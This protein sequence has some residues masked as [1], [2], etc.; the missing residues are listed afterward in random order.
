MNIFKWIF[1]NFL[2]LATLFLLAF[3]PLYPKIPLFD[4]SNTWVYI[5][6]EDFLV[7]FVL[8][9]WI[10]LLYLK[11]VSFKTP[12][13]LPILIFWLVGAVAT[14]HGVLLIFPTISN[15]FP[16]V[17]FMSLLRHFEYMSLFF[18]AYQGMRERNFLNWVIA[19]LVFTLVAVVVYGLGQRYFGFP[20]YLTMNEEFAKGIPVTLSQ[21][22]RVSSTFA[23][24]YDL[25]AYLVLIIPILV[26]LIFG[27]KNIF[28]KF[29]LL[30]TSVLGF[31]LLFM[32]VSRVS[33]F[34]AIICILLLL[35]FQK[36]KLFLISIPILLISAIFL[37]SFQT[38]LFDR[39]KNTVKEVDVLVDAD[40]GDSIGHL[41]IVEKEQLKNKIVLRKNVKDK[42]ELERALAADKND[43]M[44]S[45]SAVLQHKYI[46]ESVPLVIANNIS[47]GENLPQGT[48]YINLSLSPVTNRL[49]NFF[50]EFSPETK[51]LVGADYLVLEGNFLVKRASAYDMSFTTR[52]QGEWPRAIESFQRNILFG[53]GYGSVSL[54]ID[55]NYL[56]ILAET[57]ILGFL[58]FIL[59]FVLLGIYIK[60][61]WPNIESKVV[62]SFILGFGIGVIGLGL[63]ATLIDV[64]EASKIAFVLWLLMGVVFATLRNYS[65]KEIDSFYELRN[66]ALSNWAIALYL[67]SLTILLFSSMVEN[68]FVGD[69]FTWL[70]WAS[71]N[72]MTLLSYFTTSDGF[73]YR[74]GT[75]LYFYGMY[76]LFWLNQVIYHTVSIFLHFAVAFS[77]YILGKKIFNKI[78]LA[79]LSSFLFLILS[80]SLEAVYWI[81]STGHLFNA[82]FG[83]LGLIFFISWEDKK[84]KVYFIMSFTSFS[85][86]LLFHELGVALPL[87][88]IAYKL[89]D[90]N[91]LNLKSFVKRKDF[92]LL[93]VPVIAY[94]AVRFLANSHWFNGD[95]NYNVLKFPFN[96]IG[97]LLGYFFVNFF[98]SSI[99]PFYE[100]IRFFARE[101][102]AM[103]IIAISLVLVILYFVFKLIGSK[104]DRREKGIIMFSFS[105]FMISLLPFLGL[106]N[107]TSRYGYLASVGLIFFLVL[108]IKKLYQGM[109]VN[110]REIALAS[111]AILIGVY[112]LFQIIQ[113]QQTSF[114]WKGSGEKT[115]K[116]FISLDSLY[117]TGWSKNHLEFHFVNVPIKYGD[118][119][120]FPVGLDDA[121]W[122]SF[123]N[124]NIS[125]FKHPDINSAISAT[126]VSLVNKVLLFNEDGSITD[127]Q[128][129]L[130]EREKK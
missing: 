19:V 72:S 128:K 88:V 6:L 16:N 41:K 11:K 51:Q 93:F 3:I 32:T 10:A 120:V 119:W 35:F 114:D 47:T 81:S 122:F 28:I 121:V 63:N 125:I 55:N 103:S 79:A 46:P 27:V 7:L 26:S 8:L 60:K 42:E 84:K 70:K 126:N 100:K 61:I 33:F 21:M 104:F 90:N 85:L 58:S 37:L 29:S 96:F 20:A 40:T 113:L 77:V 116:F 18:I 73:F 92:L 43:P 62:K 12:L 49:D 14:F 127:Y 50:Y 99:L 86:A 59:I 4:V 112:S 30:M 97:N 108:V 89:K 31:L 80:G 105:F 68:F 1:N 9:F 111:I 91:L 44:G 2:F 87:L 39:F 83:L 82:F 52:F 102:V 75:K 78:H 124:K 13:T 48:G 107:I 98:G 95:Y 23:G 109:L 69:D 5:R 101:N 94:L 66:I 64:F 17:A 130:D 123:E 71:D 15:V 74:P 25:A 118:A 65:K 24:H 76:Q 36:R 67:F 56:R 115:R 129:I 106:G 54:A 117:K 110:G 45:P 38:S 34:V 53:S 57:G 22:S